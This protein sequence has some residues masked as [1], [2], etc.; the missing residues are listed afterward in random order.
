MEQGIRMNGLSGKTLIPL[1]IYLLTSS[2]QAHDRRSETPESKAVP[3]NVI[4]GPG[5]FPPSYYM[6]TRLYVLPTRSHL[7]RRPAAHLLLQGRRGQADGLGQHPVRPSDH[8]DEPLLGDGAALRDR[9]HRHPAVLPLQ[10]ADH[11]WTDGDPQAHWTHSLIECLGSRGRGP[12]S[13]AE[14]VILT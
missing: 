2:R 8:V 4:V 5:L 3:I 7:Q 13:P 1:I 12:E 10:A 14:T 11:S 6:S 9:P